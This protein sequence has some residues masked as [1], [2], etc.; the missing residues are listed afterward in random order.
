MHAV[1]MVVSAADDQA[2]R[3]ACNWTG[4]NLGTELVPSVLTDADQP[5]GSIAGLQAQWAE[6]MRTE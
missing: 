6:C 4:E 1:Y 2:A 5:V 3:C